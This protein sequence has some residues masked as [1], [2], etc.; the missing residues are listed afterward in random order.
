MVC[1]PGFCFL[2]TTSSSLTQVGLEVFE[3]CNLL[4][5]Q[6]DVAQAVKDKRI[7][8]FKEMLEASGFPDLGVVDELK[9]G[10]DLIGDVPVTHMLPSQF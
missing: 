6:C 9:L 2:R 3:G 7:L 4:Q 1:E 10:S 8:L 5:M